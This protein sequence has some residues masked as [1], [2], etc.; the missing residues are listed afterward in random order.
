ME[1]ISCI[2]CHR[3]V[4][5]VLAYTWAKPAILVEGK[6]RGSV[7]IS[8]FLHFHS[9][10]SFFPVSFFHLLYYLFYHFSPF[11]VIG[12]GKSVVCLMSLGRLADIGLQLG[13]A[14]Y[15]CSR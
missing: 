10:Y 15:P 5:L 12:C 4:Q 8:L 7:F 14:C 2:L 13:K 3:D 11:G 6:G 1:K 9:H